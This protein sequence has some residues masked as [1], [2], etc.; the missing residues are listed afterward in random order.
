MGVPLMI[1]KK[2]FM[3]YVNNQVSIKQKKFAIAFGDNAD[4][5]SLSKFV[6]DTNQIF[7]ENHADALLDVLGTIIGTITPNIHHVSNQD[8]IDDDWA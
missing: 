5:K 3:N 1:M 8:D 6:D 7:V 2:V 4:I